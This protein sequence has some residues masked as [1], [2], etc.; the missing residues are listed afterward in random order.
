M[1]AQILLEAG[2][3]LLGTSPAGD[4]AL[5]GGQ[6]VHQAVVRPAASDGPVDEP[7]AG[8]ASAPAMVSDQAL[9][10]GADALS[11][12][13]AGMFGGYPANGFATVALAIAPAT[14]KSA[15]QSDPVNVGFSSAF[16]PF[17]GL[18]ISTAPDGDADHEAELAELPPLP[19]PAP[20][21]EAPLAAQAAAL[22]APL[23]GSSVAT[24]V[25]KLPAA[26]TALAGVGPIVGSV[27]D[28]VAKIVASPDA[29]PDAALG[30]AAPVVSLPLAAP[31]SDVVVAALSDA[32]APLA[33]A[34]S[35]ATDFVTTTLPAIT[36][37]AAAPILDSVGG[38][39]D[40]A[41]AGLPAAVLAP[42]ATVAPA[43][44]AVV[45]LLTPTAAPAVEDALGDLAGSDPAAG[46]TTLI[47]LVSVGEVFELREAGDP[48][49]DDAAVDMLDT[50]AADLPVLPFEDEPSDLLSP[51]PAPAPGGD[52]GLDLGLGG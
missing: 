38:V 52:D 33:S 4:F 6:P 50:L 22:I 40:L 18:P 27:L 20:I 36:V 31:L 19:T 17:A 47:D 14:G 5:Y 39:T 42:I 26:D 48:S 29:A 7:A 15:A 10:W 2:N 12:L 11:A 51:F 43:A 49:A 45:T 9:P 25:A 37:A 16:V 41:A 13:P 8:S 3:R 1:V 24:A 21:A 30:L 44:D 23:M 32:A 28:P 46:I 35:P 34:L